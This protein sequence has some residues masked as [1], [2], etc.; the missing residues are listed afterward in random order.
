MNKS[1]SIILLIIV[2]LIAIVLVIVSY[3]VSTN[4]N[5]INKTNSLSNNNQVVNSTSGGT[6]KNG[7]DEKKIK[8]SYSENVVRKLNVGNANFVCKEN[9][10]HITGIDKQIAEKIEKHLTDM[11]GN[12]WTS[13]QQQTED[14]DILEILEVQNMNNSGDIGF[15]QSCELIYENN[16]IATFK[17][18]FEGGLGGVSWDKTSGI[19]FDINTGEKINIKD[20]ITNKDEYEKA[21]FDYVI[22]QLKEDNRYKY[23]QDGY[24]SVVRENVQKFEGYFTKDGIVCVHIPRYEMANGG[25]GEFVYAIPYKTVK[26]YIDSKYV[27]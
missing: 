22:E 6:E 1:K 26:D 12:E 3:L 13:I 11:Y 19:S 20:I 18:S 14:K 23:L 9:I 24:Q 10:P 2:G 25:A 7:D 5:G 17:C 4:Q 21:C 27:F 15:T 16:Q 8:V